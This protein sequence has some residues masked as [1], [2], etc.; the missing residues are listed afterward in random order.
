M[1]TL[2]HLWKQQKKQTGNLLFFYGSSFEVGHQ[3]KA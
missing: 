3:Q 1:L 2:T